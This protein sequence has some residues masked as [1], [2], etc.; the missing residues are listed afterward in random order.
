MEPMLLQLAEDEGMEWARQRL[1]ALLLTGRSPAGGWPG[2]LSEARLRIDAR[3][4][5]AFHRLTAAESGEIVRVAYRAAQK[6][7]IARAARD[8]MI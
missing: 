6:Y 5:A 4:G 3:L 1:A 7:W 8:P 2:T